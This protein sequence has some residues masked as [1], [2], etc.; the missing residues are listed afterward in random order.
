MDLLEKIR[1]FIMSNI[2]V[3]EDE[4]EFSDSDNIFQLG[5]VNSLFAMKL[6]NFVESEFDI[7]I[8][9]EEMDIGNF[10]SVTNIARLIERKNQ[11]V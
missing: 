10:S 8:E 11:V 1:E 2:V 6:L 3:F 9:N 5:L 4:A 7:K